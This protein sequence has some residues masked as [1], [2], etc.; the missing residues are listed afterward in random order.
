M[1]ALQLGDLAGTKLN[2]DIELVEQIGS[3]GMGVVYRAVQR[4]LQRDVCVKFMQAHLVS[5]YDWQR[6]FIREAKTLARIRHKHLAQVYSVG[7]HLDVYPY[8]VMELLKGKPLNKVIEEGVLDWLSAAKI[9]IQVCEALSVVH[10]KGFVHRDLKPDNIFIC[11]NQNEKF[12]KVLDF[13][14]AGVRTDQ[15]GF[16]TL[17]GTGDLLGTVHYMAP[18]CFKS[19][20]NHPA[21]DIYSLGCIFYQML[22]GTPPFEGDSPITIAYKHASE[23]PPALKLPALSSQE[24]TYLTQFINK[25]CSKEPGARFSN[26]NEMLLSLRSALN[27]NFDRLDTVTT[28][29]HGK[30]AAALML[31]L[32]VC[33]FCVVSRMPGLNLQNAKDH[34]R[35]G[36]YD[37]SVKYL[38]S[39]LGR[40]DIS[41]QDRFEVLLLLVECF[42]HLH[43]AEAALPVF[44]EALELASESVNKTSFKSCLVAARRLTVSLNET[45]RERRGNQMALCKLDRVLCKHLESES[46]EGAGVLVALLA[47]MHGIPAPEPGTARGRLLPPST[48]TTDECAMLLALGGIE[49][50]QNSCY[51]RLRRIVDTTEVYSEDSEQRVH[52]CY[53]TMFHMLKVRN[54]A[55]AYT[56]S[57]RGS[58]QP[59]SSRYPHEQTAM[60]LFAA[61]SYAQSGK[62]A[63][64]TTSI[65]QASNSMSR[66]LAL[67]RDK[68]WWG[69]A[70]DVLCELT[71]E[72]QIPTVIKIEIDSFVRRWLPVLLKHGYGTDSVTTELLQHTLTNS[73]NHNDRIAA[74]ELAKIQAQQFREIGDYAGAANVLLL[75]SLSLKSDIVAHELA[76]AALEDIGRLLKTHDESGRMRDLLEQASSAFS[77]PNES[78]TYREF[79]HKAFAYTFNSGH[80]AAV[81]RQI[82]LLSHTQC[83][84]FEALDRLVSSLEK[85]GCSLD[86]KISGEILSAFSQETIG[87]WAHQHRSRVLS[88]ITKQLSRAARLEPLTKAAQLLNLSKLALLAEDYRLREKLLVDVSKLTN[89]KNI[90]LELFECKLHL[91]P[92][93]ARKLC[94]QLDQYLSELVKSSPDEAFSKFQQYAELQCCDRPIEALH[95][96]IL[97]RESFRNAN[98][99]ELMVSAGEALTLFCVGYWSD[100]QDSAGIGSLI[101]DLSNEFIERPISS[102]LAYCTLAWLER[103]NR[104]RGCVVLADRCAQSLEKVP[105]K[106]TLP[107]KIL[108]YL[109]SEQF[110]EA[111]ACEEEY[112]SQLEDQSV[113]DV[114][115]SVHFFV[116]LGF[117]ALC[118][119]GEYKRAVTLQK[120]II[121]LLR[122]SHNKVFF[123]LISSCEDDLATATFLAGNVREA[124]SIWRKRRASFQPLLL[125]QLAGLQ[126]LQCLCTK[127]HSE[128]E[129]RILRTRDALRRMINARSNSEKLAALTI[130]R[131]ECMIDDSANSIAKTYRQIGILA[132]AELLAGN[133][134]RAEVLCKKFGNKFGPY[135]FDEQD[136]YAAQLFLALRRNDFDRADG[137]IRDLSADAPKLSPFIGLYV[138]GILCA[139]LQHTNNPELKTELHKLIMRYR[140]S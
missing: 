10:E 86:E 5:A 98:R 111:V 120:R 13:G 37:Q 53:A 29:F 93:E 95:T 46:D 133:G 20:Q 43:N 114:P 69:P 110:T 4:S 71:S 92:A 97:C 11:E 116:G 128:S 33:V 125:Y 26:C 130:C 15:S 74:V 108:R 48:S 103:I 28:R 126:P 70:V 90:L 60:F 73:R 38:Q 63:E 113:V 102:Q 54:L 137:I 18:E 87:T 40:R 104:Q 35:R 118:H 122:K 80:R 32:C 3:G 66:V 39:Y 2:H 49:G 58:Q 136:I 105:G 36:E 56:Y 124:E 91:N 30:H 59:R 78:R 12:A 55:A 67:K 123:R 76:L 132:Y 34:I 119:K 84:E 47:A 140:V 7:F 134:D 52:I 42:I 57:L 16:E 75:S 44:A 82:S 17:T 81:I 121:G 50:I 107:F 1:N 109:I 96:Y 99:P 8:M 31:L 61:R 129:V 51:T 14:L 19:A 94:P 27:G 62:V 106:E 77:N 72:E 65:K 6:R 24:R 23:S 135:G 89:R 83:E 25:A 68:I 41:R 112:V 88:T 21:V 22:V 138:A 9:L 115:T 127:A 45:D 101:V 79:L 139:C 117:R 131:R 100:I 64:A 85:H